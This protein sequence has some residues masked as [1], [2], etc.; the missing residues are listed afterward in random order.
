[1]ILILLHIKFF[2]ITVNVDYVVP[3]NIQLMPIAPLMD[4]FCNLNP[5]SPR[6]SDLRE[7]LF[8]MTRGG[9]EDIETRC[10]KL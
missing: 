9:D 8:N 3:E 4:G 6:N 10:L 1:M 7:S 5:S 2:F